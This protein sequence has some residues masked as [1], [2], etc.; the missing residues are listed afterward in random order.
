MRTLRYGEP[1]REARTPLADFFSILLGLKYNF[2]LGESHR[3]WTVTREAREMR[4]MH[5]SGKGGTGETG[6]SQRVTFGVRSSGNLEHRTLVYLAR[7]R[8]LTWHRVREA[9]WSFHHMAEAMEKVS[10]PTLS[11]ASTVT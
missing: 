6:M 9:G 4:A 2:R 11:T 1:L 8:R 7:Y 5:A 3:A 10:F